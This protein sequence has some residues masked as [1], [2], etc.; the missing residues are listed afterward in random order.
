MKKL[1]TI[2]MIILVLLVGTVLTA[3]LAVR[4]QFPPQRIA[5][6]ASE[7]LSKALQREITVGNASFSLWPLGLRVQD[8]QI[9]NAP[10]AGFSP[11]PFLKLPELLVQ[12]DL[13]KLLLFQVNI[14]EIRLTGLSVLLE[15]LPDGRNSLD[16]LG[17]DTAKPKT[18]AQP[19]DLSQV[20]LP[21]TFL[22]QKL[23]IQDAQIR[24]LDRKSGREVILEDIDYNIDLNLDRTLENITTNGILLLQ[25]ISVSD[26]ASGVRKGGIRISL[27]HDLGANIRNQEL[28]IRKLELGLQDIRIALQ[29][30]VRDFLKPQKEIDLSVASNEISLASLVR[31]IPPSINPEITK[32]KAEG[33]ADFNFRAKGIV[34]G[35]DMPKITGALNIAG[36]GLSHADLPAGISQLNGKISLSPEK[37]QVSPFGFR[38]G[39]QP[40]DLALAVDSLTSLPH[41]RQLQLNANLDLGALIALV[42]KVAP[43]SPGFALQGMLNAQ[44]RAQGPIEPARPERLQVDGSASLARGLLKVEEIPDS[45]QMESTVRFG[46]TRISQ[47]AKV[48]VGPSDVSVHA[49]ITD[50]LAKIFPSQAAGRTMKV[51]VQVRSTNLELDRLMPPFSAEEEKKSDIPMEQ[52]PQLPNIVANLDVQL[53]RTV[54]RH[55][56]FTDFRIKTAMRDQVIDFDLNGRTYGGS[57]LSRV[58]ADLTNRRNAQVGLFLDLR[59]VEANDF[60]SNGN[61][62]IQGQSQLAK[63]IRELDNT[64]YGKLDLL[65]DVKTLGLPQTFVDNMTGIIDVRSYDGRIV[66][67]KIGGELASAVGGFEVAGRKVLAG[68]IP[69]IADIRFRELKAE[70][71]VQNGKIAVKDFKLT[72]TPMG[73]L[74]LQGS[75]ATDASLA[76]TVV[77]TL[78]PTLSRRLD[79]LTS[80]AQRALTGAAQAALGSTGAA[81]AAGAVGTALFPKDAAGN[82]QFFLNLTGTF[83]EP[84]AGFD[85]KR[86]LEGS[87]SA[88][89]SAAPN[90]IA[91]IRDNLETKVAQTRAQLEAQAKA[92][93]DEAK[94]LAD[95]QKRAAEAKVQAK[96]EEIKTKVNTERK[97]VESKAKDEAGKALKKF[98]F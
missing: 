6:L 46:N 43:L 21:G 39:G 92:K 14:Q 77:N 66:G 70:L 27:T 61:N 60:I 52:F 13:T 34:G 8:F 51:G 44:L 83:A 15:T 28:Q 96:Q 84:K 7:Q 57:I 79:E 91:N 9:A 55:L 93:L 63:K 81:L 41:L 22:L 59:K 12:V 42:G 78:T 87:K 17:S 64:L 76:L 86:M 29:G 85:S 33:K 75:I 25:G 3:F 73:V 74:A 23:N 72:D 38:L 62:N 90:P 4:S 36:M 19:L 35:K 50:F 97:K 68:V 2:A 37:I 53:G 54:F 5:A 26:R 94:R 95:E 1:F 89:K 69:E 45:I 98:G 11:D 10:G 56:A 32:V 30:S 82:A 20:Q 71:E 67:S 18:P 80:N 16:G 40:V 48:K 49:E 24:M 88:Q 58:K 31:E 65:V 47:D